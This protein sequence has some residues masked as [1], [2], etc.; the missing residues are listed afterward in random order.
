[1]VQK[2]SVTRHR[3]LAQPTGT[4]QR[5]ISL[6]Y[7]SLR[8]LGA[9]LPL[10]ELER[11]AVMVNEAMSS[12]GR[13]FHTPEHVFDLVRPGRPHG[14]LAALFH[15][16]VYRQVDAGYVP[17][18]SRLIS[19]SIEPA[20]GGL[21]VR[22]AAGQ[23]RPLDL[24]L[25]VFGFSRGQI[26]P[27]FA[28]MNEFLSAL[29][30]NRTFTGIVKDA[31]LARASAC[32]EAT[33]P[34]RGPLPD[35]TTPAQE[36]ERRLQ[37]ASAAMGLGVG[38][39]HAREAVRRAVAFANGDVANF[40]DREVTRFLDNTWKLL[41]ETNPS[42]RVQGVY[43]VRSYRVAL[44]K[45]HGFL[46][47][48]DPATIFARHD[49]VPSDAEY[50][51]K[52]ARA[53]RNVTTARSYLG[54]K[55]LTAAVLE[56]LADISGGDAPVSLFMGD[57]GLR[58]PGSKLE[59]YLPSRRPS[60]SVRLDPTLHDLLAHGRASASSFDLQN[61][62]LSLFLYLHLGMDGFRDLLAAA[63]GLF[64]SKVQPRAFL[65]LL[66][67]ELVVPIA[68]GCA[69]M[70]FTR[71]PALEAYGSARSARVRGPSR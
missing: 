57:I 61:S 60:R 13:S 58:A 4:I 56:A 64:D 70:A 8:A 43:S 59:D 15:D 65:D 16:L 19:P 41:P 44:Q 11:V 50:R 24:T 39:A 38:G 51:Q 48:L 32:I 17:E 42:L 45:M 1:M 30:M 12:G 21:R 62:P 54:I 67:R 40:A 46:L 14:N 49:G 35:G 25:A 34:F 36:L 18:V 63:H 29:V 3:R 71:R 69:R 6:L 5:T 2:K 52:L 55:L 22:E 26:L 23:D 37:S 31:D 28:G 68:R 47:T 7:A 53:E 10:A 33:I 27:P 66:P 20:D 9:E